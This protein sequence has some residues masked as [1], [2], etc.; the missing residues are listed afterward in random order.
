MPVITAPQDFNEDDLYVDLRPLVGHALFL[1]C[2]GFNF[3]GSVKLKAATAMVRSAERSGV[4]RPGSTLVESSSGNLGVALSTIA[5]SRGYRF[6]CVTDP[7]CNLATRLLMEALGAEVHMITERDPTGGFLAARMNHVRALCASD[8]RFVWLNQYTNAEA[9]Q[10]HYRTTGPAIAQQFPHLDV[11]FVGAGTTGTLMGCARYFRRWHPSARIVAVDPVGSV[12]FGT[13]EARRMIPGLGMNVRPP[14]LDESFVDDVVHVEEA[15]AIRACH[16]LA[17]RGFLFGGST[18]TVVSGATRWLAEHGAHDLTAVAIAPDL[19]ERYL[20]TLYQTNWIRDLY[21]EDVL[22]ADAA[23]SGPSAVDP[24]ST[25]RWDGR[26]RRAPHPRLLA[27]PPEIEPRVPLAELVATDQRAAQGWGLR[28]DKS[29]DRLFEQRCGQVHPGPG[30]LVRVSSEDRPPTDDELRA[31]AGRLSRYLRRHGASAGDRIAL[32]FDR[33]GDLY[34]A[35]LAVLEIGAA[36]VPL[37]PGARAE[38]MAVVVADARVRTVLSTPRAAAKVEQIDL[39]TATG[40]ELVHLDPAL[41]TE[42]DGRGPSDAGRGPRDG[43]LATIACTAGVDGRLGARPSD[44]VRGCGDAVARTPAARSS[45]ATAVDPAGPPALPAAP[46]TGVEGDLAAVL[47][48][49]LDVAA[50]PV[51]GDFFDD[52]GADSMVMARF[53]ARL[54]KRDDLPTVSMKD[55]YAHPTVRRLAAA[56]APAAAPGPEAERAAEPVSPPR[57]TPANAGAASAV[58]GA[59]HRCTTVGEPHQVLCGALQLLFLLGYPSLQGLG[60]VLGV[61]W[62]VRG[63]DTVEVF[64]RSVLVGGGTFLVLCTVPI[65]VKWV[66]V[67]RWEPQQIRVWSLGYLRFWVV[68]TLVQRNPVVLFVGS[69]LYPLYLRALGARVGRDVAILSRTVPVCTD[70]LT[71]GAGAV[72]RKDSSFTGYRAHAGLIQTG[73]VTIGEDVLVG[74]AAVLDIRTSIG[75]GAQLGHTSALHTGQAVPAGEHWHGSPARP[76]EVD[77]RSVPTTTG[78]RVRRVVFSVVQVLNLLVGLPLV[79]CALVVLLAEVPQLVALLDAGPPAFTSATFYVDVLVV[80]SALFFGSMIVG[81][82]FVTTVPRLLNAAIE[83][84]AVYP[85]YGFRYWVHRTIARTT[86]RKFFTALF[87]DSA[88]IVGY[89]RGIGYDL[90]PVEQTGSNFGMDVKHDNPYLG[91]VGTGTVVA[92]GLSI[93]NADF[94]STSFRVSRVRVGRHNFLG[95][96]IVYPAR[97]RTGDDCLLA[98]KVL[99]PID[100]EVR[101]GVGLLGSPSFEIPRSVQR[102]VGLGLGSADE[103]RLRLAAKTRHNLVTMALYLLVRW[104]YAVLLTLVAAIAADLHD[105]WGA[106][107]VVLVTAF[108][109]LLGIPYSLLVERAC[110][111]LEALRPTGCS[112][113]DRAFWRH[114]RYWKVPMRAYLPMFNGTPLKTVLWRLLGVRVGR[115]VFD[116]GVSI[117][118]KTLVS[119]GDDC[120]LNAGSV[121]QCHSQEDGAFKSDRTVI[122]AGVTLGVGAFVHYGVTMGEGAVLAADSFLMKGEEVPAHALWGGNPATRICAQPPD[123]RVRATGVVDGAV[124][125][126]G[127]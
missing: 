117:P 35:T 68:R 37:D 42:Q 20:D 58:H 31:R 98:T 121:L 27:A 54:R 34:V 40:A 74:E 89:L 102:D 90:A 103:R 6:V 86:N 5:A 65:L 97:G 107:V 61:E 51:D 62:V 43:Q 26:G 9:W 32:L 10:A 104:V 56:V 23:S 81:L 115:R 77:Y 66:L 19:G 44:R 92:D 101:Q 126:R 106:P 88:L 2:E 100:G 79:M 41:I 45:T 80:A 71:I 69:P 110:T 87:G 99:V 55:V 95:N 112:I 22:G 75:D 36:C 70:L 52:I 25:E 94:S 116:D 46:A 29:L 109:L 49:V 15:D 113:Y 73:P 24:R 13:P 124:L 1:K 4:L 123:P 50:V 114:E 64:L 38:R 118:E 82:A 122:G 93:A 7:R 63:A 3:A 84:G 67:G 39:L 8:P 120:T 11:L 14:L 85:L 76:T 28:Q 59:R 119:I 105:T 30:G 48:E 111:R 17:R 72:I 78:S 47:A 33:P 21:G 96:N 125:V 53:C 57:T 18:G 60:V 127:R 12:S 108:V 91:S 16:R 83:P